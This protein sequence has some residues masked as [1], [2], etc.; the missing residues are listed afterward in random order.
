MFREQ[1]LVLAIVLI[2]I[3]AIL[4]YGSAEFG[5]PGF[6]ATIGGII[7]I[8]GIIVLVIWIVLFVIDLLNKAT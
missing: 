6:V 5:L 7:L 2:V 8:I 3:G 4:Y 1:L